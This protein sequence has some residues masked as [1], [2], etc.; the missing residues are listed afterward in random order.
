MIVRFGSARMTASSTSSSTTTMT[1]SAAKAASFWQPSRPQTWVSPRG[2]GA[3]G[4]DDRDVR[5]ERRDGVDRLVA[6]RR[7]DRPDE[8]VGD[9][10]VRLEVAPQREERQV[11][12]ARG[13][14][15]DHPEVAVLL[16]LERLGRDLPFD[17]PADGAEAADA[18]VAEPREDELAGDPGRDH[19]VVDEVRRQAGK[20][21]VALAL[22]D[23]LVAGREAD[24]VG[25]ALDR[26]GVAVADELGDGVAH[27]RDLVTCVTV[28]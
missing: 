17:P 5:P 1:R 11:H 4:M 8:R 28:R 19:L 2:R 25:E 9:G 21:Q 22:A 26:D 23:D 15:P 10:Q 18:R 3:L 16:D 6:V 12:R 7:L 24:E 27:R 14:A 20:R 13:V